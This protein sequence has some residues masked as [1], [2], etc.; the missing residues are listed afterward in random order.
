MLA[1]IV[2]NVS[3][4]PVPSQ[5]T[6][7]ISV[8]LALIGG[9]G[10][11]SEQTSCAV[12]V[13]WNGFKLFSRLN[14]NKIIMFLLH[15][16]TML[17]LNRVGLGSNCFFIFRNLRRRR[18]RPKTYFSRKSIPWVRYAQ[19]NSIQSFSI[20]HK[21]RTVVIFC[22]IG[23]KNSVEISLAAVQGQPSWWWLEVL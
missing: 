19:H 6:H 21:I 14:H 18:N 16:R 11:F 5:A 3:W 23:L 17:L 10:E 12:I 20:L 15:I 1:W 22:G 4:K 8:V 13:C 9:F 2:G 7:A